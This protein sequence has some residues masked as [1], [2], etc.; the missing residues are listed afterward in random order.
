MRSLTKPYC[1]SSIVFNILLITILLAFSNFIRPCVCGLE[2]IYAV[3][4]GGEEHRD[5][6]SVNYMA[7]PTDDGIASDFGKT[8][9][10]D[11]AHEHDQLLY[12]TERY[13]LSSFSYNVP[14]KLEDGNYVLVLKFCEVYF[15]ES[16][17]KV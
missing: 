14:G 17:R 6:H 16:N 1:F 7:D 9:M 15:R 10:I 2:V 13:S 5:V 12:Q 3:N 4:C 8:L 11:R